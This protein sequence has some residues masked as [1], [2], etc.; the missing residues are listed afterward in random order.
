MWRGVR[1]NF[2]ETYDKITA[3]VEKQ[4]P[5]KKRLMT[6]ELLNYIRK[7]KTFRHLKD[8]D[9]IVKLINECDKQT[10]LKRNLHIT[11]GS[12]V[13]NYPTEFR[14]L[15]GIKLLLKNDKYINELLH[16]GYLKKVH[17]DSTLQICKCNGGYRMR[18]I[19]NSYEDIP[20]I[21]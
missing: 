21:F 15:D 17:S 9:I 5:I 2:L 6:R 7:G 4:G 11:Y 1:M 12:N 10:I 8:M 3:I 14:K 16:K 19:S 20:I 13:P 18:V